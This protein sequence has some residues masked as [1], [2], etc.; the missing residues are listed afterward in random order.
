MNGMSRDECIAQG[1]LMLREVV[2][3]LA[4]AQTQQDLQRLQIRVGMIQAYAL[5]AEAKRARKT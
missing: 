3:D 1:Q 4:V 2:E 5:L